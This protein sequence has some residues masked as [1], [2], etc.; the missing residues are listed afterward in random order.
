MGRL[1]Y[2]CGTCLEHVGLV[3]LGLVVGVL[4]AGLAGGV[5]VVTAAFAA[6]TTFA[7]RA[8]VAVTTR[9]TISFATLAFATRTP[10]TV[11]A[12]T[13]VAI[14]TRAALRALG[15]DVAFR[16]L[17][18]GAH[19]QA[20]LTGLGIDLEEFHIDLVAHLQDV[21][22]LL[23]LGPGDLAH[24]QEA[25]LARGSRAGGLPCPGGSR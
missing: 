17:G 6:L 11:A 3:V 19:G 14:A 5:T 12:G 10:V 18:E 21:L 8:P 1:F 25:F 13:P 7:A 16:L 2:A 20:H 24:V 23:G 4:E 9:A 22:D 15:L